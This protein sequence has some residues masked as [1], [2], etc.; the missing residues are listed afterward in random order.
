VLGTQLPAAERRTDAARKDA[1]VDLIIGD[2]FK[3]LAQRTDA[4]TAIARLSAPQP[5]PTA[6]KKGC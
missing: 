4:D 3:G 5:A 1:A 6:Q 2:G